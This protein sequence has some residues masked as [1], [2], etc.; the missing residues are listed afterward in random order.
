M[1]SSHQLDEVKKLA[2][3]NRILIRRIKYS[4]NW[5]KTKGKIDR[6]KARLA[7]CRL[8]NIHKVTTA[9]CKKHAVVEVL[10]L[11]DSVSDKND[12][13]LSM[14]Y[15]FVRQLIYKQEWLGGEVIR[16]ELA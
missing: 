3:L 9:I 8:D 16:R 7:R 5:L 2:R 6:I 12:I 15:E 10:S 13:T 11:M 14:R 4:S 1:D